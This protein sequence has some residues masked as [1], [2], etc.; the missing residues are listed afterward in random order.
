MKFDKSMICLALAII[1]VYFIYTGSYKNTIEGFDNSKFMSACHSQ[2][3]NLYN[4][5]DPQPSTT[6]SDNNTP[7]PSPTPAPTPST[8]G[9]NTKRC[10]LTWA[11]ANSNKNATPCPSGTDKECS[12]GQTCFGGLTPSGSS[13]A[14]TTPDNTTPSSTTPDNTQPDNTTPS[15]TA[16]LSGS[17]KVPSIIT[18]S[19]WKTIFPNQTNPACKTGSSSTADVLNWKNFI[20]ACEKY[21]QF[22][23]KPIEVAAF[24][25]NMTQE[26]YGGWATAPG[27]ELAW[28]GCFGAESG[29]YNGNNPTKCT[30]YNNPSCPGMDN[31]AG[32]Y[33]RGPLQLTYCS[34]YEAAGKAIG[35]D[36]LKNPNILVQPNGGRYAFEASLWFW[37]TFDQ[38]SCC[39]G[40]VMGKTC[41]D[42]M[43]E[44][45]PDFTKTI[46]IINGG[47]ECGKQENSGLGTT[48]FLRRNRAFKRIC[49]I[50]G[51]PVPPCGT[52]CNS[53]AGGQ[54]CYQK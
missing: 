51:I 16:P 13:S 48:E 40:A 12:A 11:A 54:R 8:S 17:S 10:G 53:W 1:G 50:L 24:L 27:G 36:L 20:A 21:P 23:Q 49:G 2:C 31:G 3:Q 41:H 14:S 19:M 18:E 33:G 25:A 46:A 28:G 52:T 6:P 44:P 7:T 26:T 47:I 43:N 42:V 29:C 37:T 22:G 39:G 9:S 45:D 32:Y 35:Q 15:N 38:G 30:Q 4:L 34:N 5:I